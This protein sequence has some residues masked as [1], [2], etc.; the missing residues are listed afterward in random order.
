MHWGSANR[1]R[2]R[3]LLFLGRVQMQA[4]IAPVANE[5][6]CAARHRHRSRGRRGMNKHACGSSAFPARPI[7]GTGPSSLAGGGGGPCGVLGVHVHG[8]QSFSTV[9]SA[10]C[11]LYRAMEFRSGLHSSDRTFITREGRAEVINNNMAL[12]AAAVAVSSAARGPPSA[13]AAS[14]ARRR[15]RRGG[16]GAGSSSPSP[17]PLRQPPDRL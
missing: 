10:D 1:R 5:A 17:N 12:A 14:A 8:L 4:G 16:S 13:V 11:W 6:C 3:G 7:P 15:R 2:S 9:P